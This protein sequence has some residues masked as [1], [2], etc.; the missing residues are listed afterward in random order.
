MIWLIHAK[1]PRH[2]GMMREDDG[3]FSI[4]LLVSPPCSGAV[5]DRT[6]RIIVPM[7]I[8]RVCFGFWLLVLALSAF[9]A[10]VGVVT[11]A[12]GSARVLR[13]TVWYMLAP[14]A[15][16]QEGDVIDAGERTQVQLELASGGTLNVVGPGALF[17]ASIPIRNDKQDAPMEFALDKGWLKVVSTG[18]GMRIRTS[19]ATVS[20]ADATIVTRQDGKLFELFVESGSA[21]IADTT[22]TGRDGAVHDAKSGEYWSREADK[23]FVTERHAPAKFVSAMPRHLMDRLATLAAKFKGKRPTLSVDRE[24]TLAEADPWLTGPYRRAFARRLSGRLAD[25]TFRKAVE[26]NSAAYPDFDR[27]LHPEKYPPAEAGAPGTPAAPG[28]STAAPTSARAGAASNRLPPV[29]PSS[30]PGK[31]N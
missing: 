24:I 16:F 7:K 9:A 31:P 27:V 6:V 3:G 12:E 30:A 15:P 4:G 11:I 29:S 19:S 23:P 14:G 22:R 17:A 13:G 25:P 28:A 2:S 1:L 10:D 18:A 8:Y 5:A 26:A 21:R 20:L